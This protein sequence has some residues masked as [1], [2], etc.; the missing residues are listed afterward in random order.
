[1]SDDKIDAQQAE[2]VG[3]VLLATDFTDELADEALDREQGA[4]F[5]CGLTVSCCRPS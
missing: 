3:P 2:P 4:R 1:M 5:S